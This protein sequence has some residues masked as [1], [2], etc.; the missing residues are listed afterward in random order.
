VRI[1]AKG[2][3]QK[4]IKSLRSIAD[5][6]TNIKNTINLEIPNKI[7]IFLEFFLSGSHLVLHCLIGQTF[8]CVSRGFP[9]I[10][11]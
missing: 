5:K 7:V 8:N 6:Q 11:E 3:W 10:L 4:I 9:P 2:E 1:T